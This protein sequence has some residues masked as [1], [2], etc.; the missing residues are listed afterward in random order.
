MTF[1]QIV[2]FSSIYL[3]HGSVI[4]IYQKIAF[5]VDTQQL[6]TEIEMF[7]SLNHVD[8]NLKPRFLIKSGYYIVPSP[9]TAFLKS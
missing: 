4:F 7:Q 9:S 3:L 6:K 1:Y 5:S 8:V 2:C